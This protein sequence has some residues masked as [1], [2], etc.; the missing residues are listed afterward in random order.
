MKVNENKP[1]N[2]TKITKEKLCNIEALRFIFCIIIFIHHYYGKFRLGIYGGELDFL[3]VNTLNGYMAVEYFFIIAGFFLIYKFKQNQPV[4]DFIKTKIIRLWPLVAFLFILYMIVGC[5]GLVKFKLYPNILALLLLE[6]IGITLKWGNIADDWFVSVLFFVSIF[7]FYIFKYFK[8]TTYNFFIPIVVLLCYTF[9]IQQS[10][11]GMGEHI[12]TYYG[13]FNCGLLRGIGGMGLG[14]LIYQF[15][16]YLNNQTFV[17]NLKSSII[18]TVIEGYLFGFVVYETGFHKI[19]FNN[20]IILV[21][22]FCGLLLTFLLKRGFLSKLLDNKFSV[23]LGRY[24]FALYMTHCFLWHLFK[25]YWV[26]SHVNTI[27]THPYLTGI[28]MFIIAFIFA[29]FAYHCVEIPAGKYLKK[30]LFA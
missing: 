22:T 23:I 12:K 4:T 3:K 21:I 29:I 7:Y 27:I 17:N 10:N 28:G 25:H 14:Y 6:N 8:K 13:I 9:L 1:L 2:T 30:K 15:Y 19:S 11:G 18:Y 16:S 26:D 20:R 24:S 5:F